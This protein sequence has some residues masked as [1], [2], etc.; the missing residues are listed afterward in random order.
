M[1]A[2]SMAFRMADFII[3]RSTA[4]WPRCWARSS[5][6]QATQQCR[7]SPSGA[8][9]QVGGCGNQA[10]TAAA[11]TSSEPGHESTKLYSVDLSA[12]AAAAL[13]VRQLQQPWQVQLYLGSI[14]QAMLGQCWSLCACCV[15][16]YSVLY[17]LTASVHAVLCCLLLQSASCHALWELSCECNGPASN[18]R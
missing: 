18:S 11:S 1:H 5:S 12:T 7:R 13:G 8:S 2:I 17:V 4:S 14:V 16:T 15:L 10:T 3:C 9:S 6:Q